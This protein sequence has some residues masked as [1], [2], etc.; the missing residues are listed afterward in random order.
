MKSFMK[1]EKTI[2]RKN[3]RG[4]RGVESVVSEDVY[5]DNPPRERGIIIGIIWAT[6]FN[7]SKAL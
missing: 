4:A 7:I 3:P 5:D 1:W 2:L 6:R